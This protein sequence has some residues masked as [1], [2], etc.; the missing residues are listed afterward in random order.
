MEGLG[1]K[2]PIIIVSGTTEGFQVLAERS[3]QVFARL[4]KDMFDLD[5]FIRL[6]ETA[7]ADQAK[8]G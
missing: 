8:R 5:E 2:I 7:L 4:R 3:Y 1:Q 6:V